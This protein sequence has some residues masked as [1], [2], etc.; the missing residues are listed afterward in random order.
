MQPGKFDLGCSGT[1]YA[2]A[3][4]QGLNNLQALLKVKNYRRLSSYGH[5]I[6]L[7]HFNS[8][9]VGSPLPVGDPTHHQTPQNNQP[10]L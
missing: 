3:I 5:P 2:F 6:M 7:M 8:L 4:L 10:V 1:V 9:P